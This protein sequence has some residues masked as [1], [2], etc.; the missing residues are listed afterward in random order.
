MRNIEELQLQ[1]LGPTFT[2]ADVQA[3][4]AHFAVALPPDYLHFLSLVNGGVPALNCYDY[5]HED[6]EQGQI[7]V[8]DLHYVTTD[9]ED[10]GGIWGMTQLLRENLAEI[11]REVNVV[12]VARDGSINPI[13][14]NMFEMPPSVHIL[15]LDDEML[16]YKI[17]DSFEQFIDGLTQWQEQSIYLGDGEAVAGAQNRLVGLAGGGEPGIF[18]PRDF[19]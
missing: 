19:L 5:I 12:A 1:W 7:T 18:R 10:M 4:E 13:Y 2:D 9:H 16:D 3:L 6:G 15:Y 11:E 8:G 14:L 17:A